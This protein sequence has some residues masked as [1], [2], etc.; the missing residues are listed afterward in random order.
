MS[1]D[2]CGDDFVIGMGLLTMMKRAKRIK[3]KLA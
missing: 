1:S 3:V 2:D